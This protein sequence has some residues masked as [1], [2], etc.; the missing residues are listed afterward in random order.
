MEPKIKCGVLGAGWWATFAHIPALLGHPRADLIAIQN[1]D[2]E[3]ARKVAADFGVPHACTTTAELLSIDGWRAI[4]ISSSPHLHYPQ[5]AAAL[6]HGKHVLIEKPMTLTAAQAH[7]LLELADSRNLEFLISCPWHYTSHATIAQNLIREGKLSSLHMVS[8]LMTNPIDHL[9]RGENTTPT[10]SNGA[11]YL[12]PQP[13]TYSNPE[14]A[15]GGQIY[16]QVSHVA[17]YLTFLTGMSATDVFARFHNDG[18][19]LDIYNTLNIRKEDGTIVNIASTAATSLNLRTYEMRIFGT[20]S[21]WICGG[22]QWNL[23][24]WLVL[25][26][27]IPTS[28]RSRSIRI[29][30]RLRI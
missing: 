3:R 21:T 25:R 9:L 13:G 29:R 15:G 4:L 28:V 27:A 6:Q 2:C 10:H 14:I 20:R 16:A 12:H 5:A 24:A 30:H 19:R 23:P 8:V 17:A 22:A 26:R 11:S 1:N 18:A 7:E